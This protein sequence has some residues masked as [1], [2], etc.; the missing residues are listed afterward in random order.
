MYKTLLEYATDARASQTGAFSE[1]E[2]IEVLMSEGSQRKAALKL[3]ISQSTIER[4]LDKIRIRA[5]TPRDLIK[6]L[7]AP[8]PSPMAIKGTS[9][10][11]DAE[12]G[13]AKIAWIKTD[14]DKEAQLKGILD[15]F[16]STLKSYKPLKPVKPPT[17]VS[18][19]LLAVFPMGDPHIGMHSFHMETGEDFDLKIAERDL[20]TAMAHLVSKTPPCET[21]II[22]N[23]G[24]FF[25]ADS[26][27]NTTTRGTAVDV[28][29]RFSKVLQL[30]ITLMID[31]VHMALQRNKFVVVKNN[32]GNHDTET[33]QVLS[34]CMMH[35]FKDN[36][37]VTIANPADKFFCYEFGKNALFSTHGDAVKPGKIQGVIS[38]YY[39]EV[40]GRTSH[41]LC[42]MGHFHHEMRKEE[43][44]LVTEIFNT[45]ASTDSWHHSSGY[46]SKRNMKALVLDKEHG[47][48]ERF[49]YSLNR[50]SLKSLK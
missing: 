48:I 25:H 16:T 9:T 15:T 32:I 28:D 42:L 13:Q 8:V 7:D 35:A 45:L 50:N 18:K 6:D 46:R 47:E 39:P 21:A 23:L 30:G 44:G 38:N 10:L 14:V 40:W 37:R 2:L 12:T 41:R 3:G 19:D 26:S 27:K 34:V 36:K 29:G 4:C 22:L 17:K 11:Y 24:D 20:R 33:S 1:K 31:C 49:T 43:N 5:R